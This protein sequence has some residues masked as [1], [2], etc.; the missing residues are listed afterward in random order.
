MINDRPDGE[1]TAASEPVHP[2]KI[3]P[4]NTSAKIPEVR[5]F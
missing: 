1:V 2:A 5:T 4:D 3:N